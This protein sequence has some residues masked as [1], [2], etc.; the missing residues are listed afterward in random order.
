MDLIVCFFNSQIVGMWEEC[1]AWLSKVMTQR[2]YQWM[3]RCILGFN[4]ILIHRRVWMM[5]WRNHELCVSDYRMALPKSLVL[6]HWHNS[7]QSQKAMINQNSAAW[8]M[9]ILQCWIYEFN[10]LP[11]LKMY[12]CKYENKN[13]RVKRVHPKVKVLSPSSKPKWFSSVEHK[14]I[15]FEWCSSFFF[16]T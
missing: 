9:L 3:W 2:M 10:F 12:D 8:L 13:T 16:S 7:F 5:R 4:W 11:C 14:R 15:H 1:S 6:F